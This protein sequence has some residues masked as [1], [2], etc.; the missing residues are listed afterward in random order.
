MKIL[1]KY[2]NKNVLVE[3]LEDYKVSMSQEDYGCAGTFANTELRIEFDQCKNCGVWKSEDEELYGDGYCNK[4]AQMCCDCEQYFYHGDMVTIDDAGN[5]SCR[6]CNKKKY[7]NFDAP[8]VEI[9]KADVVVTLEYIGEGNN[10]DFVNDGKDVPLMRFGVSKKQPCE[11]GRD[12]PDWNWE[13]V[14]NA[15][16]CTQIPADT[17]KEIMQKLA[18]IILN[19]IYDDVVE[20]NSVKKL[21]EG[22]SWIDESWIKDDV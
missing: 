14:E 5:Y 2:N 8:T 12:H 9:S 18:V 15:S 10:G 17:S 4:C 1:I 13:E 20:G 16:Y 22:L 3:V 19:K 21:C 6:S 11:D 7:E